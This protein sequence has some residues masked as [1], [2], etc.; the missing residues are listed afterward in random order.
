MKMIFESILLEKVQEKINLEKANIKTDE[1]APEYKKEYDKIVA[2]ITFDYY[3]RLCFNA[4]KFKNLV[5]ACEEYVIH[6]FQRENGELPTLDKIAEKYLNLKKEAEAT[7]DELTGKIFWPLINCVLVIIYTTIANKRLQ[8]YG[9]NIAKS[10]KNIV[11]LEAEKN[12]NHGKI[13]MLE[14]IKARIIRATS[15][16]ITSPVKNKDKAAEGKEENIDMEHYKDESQRIIEELK[17]IKN[18]QETEFYVYL[19]NI[20]KSL[21]HQKN[22][23]MA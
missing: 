1:K 20:A 18:D 21:L 17:K 4:W 3:K 12:D 10:N 22:L 19:K 8:T 7:K 5:L 2:R 9:E 23:K 13:V 16:I 15:S 11:S 6:E 14:E